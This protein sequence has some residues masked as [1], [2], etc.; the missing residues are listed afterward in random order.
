MLRRFIVFLVKR[1]LGVK[2]YERFR[3]V[4]QKS[5]TDYYYFDCGCNLQKVIQGEFYNKNVRASVSFNWILDDECEIVK[6][7]KE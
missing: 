4:N 3:F 6:I 1:K 7:S 5:E 2:N